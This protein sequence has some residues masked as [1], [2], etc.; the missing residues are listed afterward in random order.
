MSLN[1]FRHGLGRVTSGPVGKW[2]I[3]L[4]GALLVFS[5]VFSGLGNNLGRGRGGA[6]AGPSGAGSE[7][8]ATV[9]GDPITRADYAQ[10]VDNFTNQMQMMGQS[11]S[12]LRAASLHQYA[13]DQL[14]TRA[15]Q[16]QQAK[17]MGLTASDSEIARQRQQMVNEAG[18]AEKLSLK[19]GASITDIDAAL[20]KDG[21][22]SIEDRLPDD[23]VRQ[24]VLLDKLQT[25]QASKTQVTEADARASYKQWHTR[26]ILVDTKKRSDAQAQVQAQQILAKA[27]AP[28][29]DFAALAKLYSD[30]PGTKPAGG[31]DGWIDQNTGYVPEFKTAAFALKPGEITLVKSPQY[32]YFI[33]KAD[34]VR[35]NVPKDF[36]KNKAQYIAQVK[37]QRQSQDQ[38]TALEALKAA[39]KIVVSDPQLRADREMA[40]A[41]ALTDPAAQQAAYKTA[42][43]DYQKALAANPPLSQS[44]EINAQ[45]ASIYQ[46]LHQT[47]QAIV[48]YQAALKSTDDPD[49]RMELGNLYLQT[50]EQKAALAQFQ[51]ASQEAWDNQQLHQQLMMTYLQMKRPDLFAKEQAWLKQYTARQKPSPFTLGA[52]AVAGQTP[53]PNGQPIPV[54]TQTGKPHSG[55]PQAIK[56]V[57][58]MPA[59]PT[60]APVQ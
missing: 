28:G 43:T 13:L 47:P 31:D 57:P 27:K 51:A 6:A 40:A 26:H 50:K 20:A 4:V 8:I 32:G 19:P 37:Q 46:A 52:S 24:Y 35:D 1:S 44:G 25:V 2:T 23:T 58:G 12:I 14:V 38:Q 33:I 30:D 39:A 17:K 56:V 7:T 41:A 16:L 22:S 48:A 18:L 10:A 5:L 11:P 45:I 42:L 60:P 53:G 3:F 9:N 49:L 54:T 36:D 15:L 34:A 55:K 59:K 21:Q 29:A